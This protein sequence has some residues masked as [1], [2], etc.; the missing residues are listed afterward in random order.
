MIQGLAGTSDIQ[1][2]RARSAGRTEH[3]SVDQ[4]ARVEYARRVELPL[5]G[6]KGRGEWLGRCV[7]ARSPFLFALISAEVG[8]VFSARSA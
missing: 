1:G 4:D 8:E 6:A 7:S 5:G 2:A 3:E